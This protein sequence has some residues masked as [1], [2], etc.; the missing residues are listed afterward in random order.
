MFQFVKSN[1]HH[2][3]Y[4][5]K[6]DHFH[7]ISWAFFD[8]LQNMSTQK[9]QNIS[10]IFFLQ[11]KI[12][13]NLIIWV[14]W[15]VKYIYLIKMI[16]ALHLYKKK[17]ANYKIIRVYQVLYYP[18]QLNFISYEKNWIRFGQKVAFVFSIQFKMTM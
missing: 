15:M 13:P 1:A 7:T 3:I 17:A 11:L 9:F 16:G 12:F 18:I 8:T 4:V 2:R 10:C 6:R 5:P 14:G